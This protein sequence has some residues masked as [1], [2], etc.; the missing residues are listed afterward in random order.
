MKKFQP[1]DETE[2]PKEKTAGIENPGLRLAEPGHSARNVRVPKRHPSG[3][4]IFRGPD[5]HGMENVGEV[6]G[7][8]GL[9]G[10][11]GGAQGGHEDAREEQQGPPVSRGHVPQRAGDTNRRSVGMVPYS[12]K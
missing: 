11:P 4:Q 9:P 1:A 3:L 8:E 5:V 7:E 12:F 10:K 2:K 6:P